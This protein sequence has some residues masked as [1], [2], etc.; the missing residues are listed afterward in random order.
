[1]S[2]II[3]T[4]RWCESNELFSREVKGSKNQT[5]LVEYGTR[6]AGPYGA[7]WHCECPAFKFGKGKECKHIEAVKEEHCGYGW[8]AACGSPANDWVDGKCPKCGGKVVPVKVA[9]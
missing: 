2:V 8:G 9:I 4:F 7:N 1:M 5:Y 3:E 6:V